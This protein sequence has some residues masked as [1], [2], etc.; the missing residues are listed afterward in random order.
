M[1]RFVLLALALGVVALALW[2]L[3]GGAWPGDGTGDATH[4]EGGTAEAK[5]ALLRGHAIEEDA[6]AS[7]ADE[8]SETVEPVA[9]PSWRHGTITGRVVGPDGMPVSDAMAS[10]IGVLSLYGG[11][12]P[13][14]SDPADADGHFALHAMA[15]LATVITVT[16]PGYCVTA[17][18]RVLLR[19]GESREVGTLRLVPEHTLHVRVVDTEGAPVP[20]VSVHL[21]AEAD[22]M[23]E[24]WDATLEASGVLHGESTDDQGRILFD[25]LPAGTWRVF[26]DTGAAVTWDQVREHVET[27]G[28]EVLF[29]VPSRVV[30]ETFRV[31][32]VVLGPDG[33]PVPLV[34][35]SLRTEEE[36][37]STS[38]QAGSDGDLELEDAK[39]PVTLIV[40]G[41]QDESS[42]P[43][44]FGP[45]VIPDART[46][47]SPAAVRMEEGLT[48]TGRVLWEGEPTTWSVK[49]SG[50]LDARRGICVPG[51][52]SGDGWPLLDF[53][54]QTDAA[55][56]FRLVGL[57][58]GRF[59]VWATGPGRLRNRAPVVA[60]GSTDVVLHMVPQ[61][62]VHVRVLVPKG[63]RF[64]HAY[65]QLDEWVHGG[66]RFHASWQGGGGDLPDVRTFDV[67]GLR[68]DG[69]Y[70]LR[71]WGTCSGVSCPVVVVDD[72]V[73]QDVPYVVQLADGPHVMGVVEREDGT[74]VWGV[75]VRYRPWPGGTFEPNASVDGRWLGFSATDA[76]GVFD[77]SG[78]G[79]EDVLLAV[80]GQGLTLRDP[81]P[82]VR[83][84]SRAVRLVVV[85]ARRISGRVSDP[86]GGPVDGLRVTVVRERGRPALWTPARVAADGF[87]EVG[88]L[89]TG[90]YRIVIWNERDPTDPR[91]A[92]S[93]PLPAGR[94]DVRLELE[95]GDI[96]QGVV[97][98]ATGQEVSG[99]TVRL[100]GS[101]TNR[102]TRT[103][104]DGRYAF[105][106]IPPGID[107]DVE[108]VTPRGDSAGRPYRATGALTTTTLDV[109]VPAR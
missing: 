73:P 23:P 80:T 8:A 22:P 1:W 93:D 105:G 16:A 92:L 50:W 39:G 75:Q 21:E 41:A 91:Y 66:V 86:A 107:Y 68:Q 51:D 64:G 45:V 15:G 90:P 49:A 83:S 4:R 70:R 32:V 100:L 2:G 43:L 28:D 56:F 38:I 108:V 81:P 33:L 97:R 89:A 74:P 54:A 71:V 102:A 84:G 103:D 77:V 26:L 82:R 48:I 58:P 85:P 24:G 13:Y 40:W 44:G 72:V 101:W 9:P 18:P 94:R 69:R 87:F 57:P 5:D 76:E 35:A 42:M 63:L 17:G 10:A 36:Y 29:V 25:K 78:L 11:A 6:E 61:G 88:G 109:S 19:E 7:A 53:Q 34:R 20:D 31:K 30:P 55:G 79:D 46:L 99:A 3:G 104:R 98:V 37:L 27:G 12:N 14:R 59:A 60:A 47:E 65:V 96:L 52:E 62:T 106:G 67:K 95:R